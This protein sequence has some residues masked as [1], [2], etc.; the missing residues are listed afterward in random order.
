MRVCLTLFSGMGPPQAVQA[1][2]ISARVAFLPIRIEAWFFSLAPIAGRL[3]A[4]RTNP[5]LAWLH[6]PGESDR[7]GRAALT[8]LCSLFIDGGA[9][10]GCVL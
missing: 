8:W 7:T 5:C 4:A 2:R 9:D 6:A 10:C 1:A 3:S